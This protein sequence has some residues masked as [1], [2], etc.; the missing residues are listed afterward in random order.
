MVLELVACFVDALAVELVLE[1]VVDTVAVVD[2]LAQTN[3]LVLE[4]AQTV[5]FVLELFVDA[6]AQCI[7]LVLVDALD[8]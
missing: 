1:L 6:V 7:D 2:A 4:L 5:E 8:V 3:E